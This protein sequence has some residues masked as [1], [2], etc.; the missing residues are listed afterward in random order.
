MSI[1]WNIIQ[2][3]K[4]L[5]TISATT[6]MNLKDIMKMDK[7]YILHDFIMMTFQKRQGLEGQT[8]GQ[9]LQGLRMGSVVDSKGAGK[10]REFCGGER[11][12]LYLD[13]VDGY[14]TY[15]FVKTHGIVHCNGWILLYISAIDWMFVSLPP[16]FI[17]WNL[18][19][20]RDGVWR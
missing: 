19:P 7:G 4:E 10:S 5:S 11:T 3:P 8:R 20:Q 2:Q 18:I 16:K 15:T 1:H 9:W 13:C 17:C 14:L 6:W 12:V